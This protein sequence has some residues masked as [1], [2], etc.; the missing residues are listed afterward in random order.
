LDDDDDDRVLQ[1]YRERRLR[2][3]K[4]KAAR[5]RFGE[6][7]EINKAEWVTEVTDASKQ[8]WVVVHLY[9]DR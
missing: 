3:L 4:E 5:E 8:S 6:V 7:V 1:S 2:E 9:K